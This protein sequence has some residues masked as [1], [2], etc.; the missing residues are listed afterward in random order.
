MATNIPWTLTSESDNVNIY[1]VTLSAGDTDSDVLFV[2][3]SAERISI[4]AKVTAGQSVVM[5]CTNRP[6]D[7]LTFGDFVGVLTLDADEDNIFWGPISAIM[8][9]G[10]VTAGSVQVSIAVRNL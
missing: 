6:Q 2:P 1:E 9:S 3:L 10:T 8:L 4:F 5:Q 7:L